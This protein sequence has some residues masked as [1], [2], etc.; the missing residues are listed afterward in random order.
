VA[1]KEPDMNSPR[2]QPGVK[3]KDALAALKELN[4][5]FMIIFNINIIQVLSITHFYQ[6]SQK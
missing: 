4:D 1:L 5:Q 3:S 6:T 2:R